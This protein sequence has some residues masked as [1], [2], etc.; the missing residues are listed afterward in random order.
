MANKKNISNLF[1]IISFMILLVMPSII[2]LSDIKINKQ[3]NKKENVIRKINNAYQEDFGLKNYLV[4]KYFKFKNNIGDSPSPNTC[5]IGK[6]GWY[7]LGNYYNNL[8]DDNFGHKTSIDSTELEVIKNNILSTKNFLTSKGIDFKIIVPPNKHRVYPEHLPYSH[9]QKKTRLEILNEYL[10]KEINFEIIYLRDT[11]VK[12]KGEKLLYYKT[13]T[14]WNDYGA[15][16]GYNYTMKTLNKTHNLS[17]VNYEDYKEIIQPI[18]END[19]IRQIN[20]SAK[21]YAI[22]LQKKKP[23]ETK[24]IFSQYHKQIFSNPN[25]TKKLLMHRDSFANAWMGFFNESFGTTIYLRGYKLDKEL[26]NKE[27]PDI[28]IFEMVERNVFENLSK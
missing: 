17:V 27:K 10:K 25:K 8:F 15:Y 6:N 19:I 12:A 3:A 13:N 21:E 26:I 20:L 5:V 28:V 11:L 23:I 16:I 24:I 18:K 22:F 4:N 14:H 1:T 9:P 2:M 7:F